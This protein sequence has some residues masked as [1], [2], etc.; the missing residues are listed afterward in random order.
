[1]DNITEYQRENERGERNR[2][3]EKRERES[4]PFSTERGEWSSAR[5][6]LCRYT[7][8]VKCAQSQVSTN[9][10]SLAWH[11]DLNH[12]NCVACHKVLRFCD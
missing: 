5:V 8:S 2:E 9:T 3:R 7:T 4:V 10:Y 12:V 6:S 1:M 11:T